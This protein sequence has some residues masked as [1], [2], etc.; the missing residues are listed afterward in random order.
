MSL[1]RAWVLA[2]V[3]CMGCGG[4]IIE[5]DDPGAGTGGSSLGGGQPTAG[6]GASASGD[7]SAPPDCNW[8]HGVART[9]DDGCVVGYTCPNGDDAC[10]TEPCAE[11]EACGAGRICLPDGLCWDG[12]MWCKDKTCEGTSNA[13]CACYWSCDDDRIYRSECDVVADG[14]V[15]CTCKVNGDAYSWVCVVEQGGTDSC[16]L[17]AVCCGF[18][19]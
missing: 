4:E 3:A 2:L 16:D 5:P 7:C 1:T 8:C 10:T 17:G 19:Q 9:D 12:P 18:P 11:P 15:M 13:E 6:S 14:S